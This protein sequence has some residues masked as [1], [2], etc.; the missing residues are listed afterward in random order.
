MSQDAVFTLPNVAIVARRVTPPSDEVSIIVGGRSISGWKDVRIT[1]GI[2]RVPSDFELSFTE[3]PNL[4]GLAM[5]VHPGD[6]CKVMIGADLVITGYIDRVMPSISPTEHRIVASGRGRCQDLVDC[7][8]NYKGGQMI[9]STVDQIATLLAFPFDI[10]IETSGDMG[11][12]IPAINIAHGQTPFEIIENICRFRQILAYE[13]PNGNLMLS[14]EF[15]KK[16]GSGFAEGVNVQHASAVWSMDQRYSDYWVYLQNLDPLQDVTGGGNLVGQCQDR[17]VPRFRLHKIVSETSGSEM[18]LDFAQD[19]ATWEG[20]RRVGRSAEIR[21]TSDGWRDVDGKLFEPGMLVDINAP[22]LYM[23][24]GPEDLN[25]RFV[26]SELTYRKDS[27]GTTLDVVAMSP[28][29]FK[30]QPTVLSRGVSRDI[31]SLPRGLGK[32]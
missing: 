11:G 9:I 5:L 7:S 26:I 17:G 13:L 32:P 28:L 10:G 19:R 14:R 22:S 30:P 2:E 21:L 6:E 3:S 12:A 27:N 23:T 20:S 15:T 16:A 31:L 29:A 25:S 8:A 18:G 4:K 1:R 24:S